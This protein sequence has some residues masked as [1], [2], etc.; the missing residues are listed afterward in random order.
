MSR[1]IEELSKKAIIGSTEDFSEA[2][3]YF[4]LEVP[5]QSNY[6]QVFSTD[7]GSDLGMYKKKLFSKIWSYPFRPFTTEIK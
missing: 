3:K 2:I 1:S 6:Y 5:G 7:Y 4:L